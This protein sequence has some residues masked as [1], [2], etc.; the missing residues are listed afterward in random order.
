MGHRI[1]LEEIERTLSGLPGIERC[2]CVFDE[3][4]QKLYGF[5]IGD[6]QKKDIY[7]Q[8]RNLLPVYMIPGALQPVENFPLTKNGKTDR[9]LLLERRHM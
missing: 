4:K 6:A 8:L 5:Y 9:K 7:E 2:C 3:A 1:E